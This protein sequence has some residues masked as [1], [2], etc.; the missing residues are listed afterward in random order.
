M[1]P[2]LLPTIPAPAPD[3]STLDE[4]IEALWHVLIG[5]ARRP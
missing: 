1:N 5:C 4:G 2:D 3:P